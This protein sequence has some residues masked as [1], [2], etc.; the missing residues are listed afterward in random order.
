[1]T[2]SSSCPRLLP[3]LACRNPGHLYDAAGLRVIL[4]FTFTSAART[5][6]IISYVHTH[7]HA[8]DIQRRPSLPYLSRFTSSPS[9]TQ[10]RGKK[11]KSSFKLDDLPQG[12]VKAEPLPDLQD[13]GS[14]A[15]PT[16]VLQA[17]HNMQKFE[18]CILLTRVGGFYE[19]YFEHAEE[20][21]PLLN[22]KVA[23]KK[24]NAGPV[25][26][27]GFPFFQLERY[28]KILV[29]DFNYYVA[30]AEEFPNDPGDK[31]KS[32]GLM[33]DRR[34]TR[35]I[36]P[37]TLIDENFI[38]P[39]ANNYVLAIHLDHE[40]CRTST[41]VHF[42]QLS[43]VSDDLG[44]PSTPI[45]LAWLDVSTGQFY[46]QATTVT[47]LSSILSRVGPREIVV[48]KVLESQRDHQL[49]SILAEEKHL[50]TFAPRGDFLPISEWSPMLESEISAQTLANFTTNEAQA[51]SLLLQYVKD[52]LQGLSMKLQPPLRHENLA[53]LTIDK[54]TMRALEIKQTIKDGT[55]RG[56]L[57][58]AIRRTVTKG[59]ARLL[60]SWISAPSTCLDTIQA[61]QELVEYF[62]Q[63]EDHR[64]EIILLLRR[65]HD[66]QRL[67]QKFAFGRGDAD[68]LVGLANTIRAV[69]DI[70]NTLTNT[71]GLRRADS[72][73]PDSVSNKSLDVDIGSPSQ[74]APCFISLL[75]RIELEEPV[76]LA[77]RIRRSIDEEGLIQ[78]QHNE[79]D[80]ASHLLNLAEDIVAAEGT[81]SDAASLPKGSKKKKPISIRDHYADDNMA[82]VMK[83]EASPGLYRLHS[84]L[85]GLLKEKSEMG[86][87][88]RERFDAPSLTLRWTPNLGHICHVKG[89]DVRV[90]AVT[91]HAA[92][93]SSRTTRTFHVAEW[94]E[95]GQ[96]IHQTRFEIG[97]EESRIFT[98][99]RAAVVA[100]LVKLRRNASV[101]DEL[102]IT[103][104]FARLALEQGLTRPVL[105]NSTAHTIIG[106]RHPTVEGGLREQ[107]R[108]FTKND[109]LVGHTTNATT[110][111]PAP[112]TDSNI[113]QDNPPAA[114]L[115]HP[116]EGRL[117]LIT[118]P[119]MAGK[120]TYLRQNALITI[121]AQ[122]GCYVP[123]WH[124]T[125]GI[126]D[127]VFSR[128]GSADNLYRD[129]STFMVEMLETAQ[130]LG[131]ATPRSFVIMDEIGR[132]TTPEDGEAVAFA[133]LHHL[134]TVNRC[135]TLFATHFHGLADL[136]H[137]RRLH[138]SDG[139]PVEMYCTDVEEDGK[140]GFVYVH[141]L[142]KGVNRQSH[143][144]KVARLAGLPETAIKMANDILGKRR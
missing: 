59:G 76:K 139:A 82:F 114:S 90:T 130:I 60:D 53:V 84:N 49:F 126:V 38:D 123:A 127:A 4:P 61:R 118:G 134:A 79:D 74:P 69:Q 112:I 13:D 88:L 85:A 102:D 87:T 64:D 70:F 91:S 86:D 106:G 101:L 98:E 96:R 57:L 75:S 5:K 56:S 22:L 99:L 41:D 37:G 67:V 140:G 21:G 43:T 104:S 117:W 33:H 14:P 103:T 128:V 44:P 97:T 120:S 105:N 132:G 31:V 39:Y 35:V 17:R 47:S 52:R 136:V 133:C 46:T 138:V 95:L 63:N 121:L 110:I 20:Y 8:R 113:I 11:T 137:E 77:E 25:S 92:V 3:F 81:Q 12:L 78:Q 32:G 125:L 107:G 135:R 71:T 142:R 29:V 73:E 48:D 50:V 18:N 16:V 115:A 66:S 124:A 28:L 23:Q 26:M 100:N 111:S 10:L 93:S 83:P 27:A 122:A 24:T 72:I 58:H 9:S 62:I 19:L 54:N 1:M 42:S 94:T 45:G 40:A 143:A 131:N 6:S 34:V 65:S 2:G 141:K 7:A 129:Q 144:L 116:S 51:G 55:F 36:T 119:N 80:E 68:D 89:K 108:S 109:C 15:Y 30:I